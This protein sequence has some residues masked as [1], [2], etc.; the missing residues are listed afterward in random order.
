[1]S[2][3]L[4][5]M[6]L[7]MNLKLGNELMRFSCAIQSRSSQASIASVSQALVVPNCGPACLVYQ[8][9]DSILDVVSCDLK[10]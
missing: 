5:F 1:M 3:G 6:S 8:V 10:S 9:S 2:V 7:T 4:T